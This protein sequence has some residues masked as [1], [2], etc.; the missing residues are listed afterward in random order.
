LFDRSHRVAL[1][2]AGA[3]FVERAEQLLAR[4][5]DAAAEARARATSENE[6]LRVGTFAQTAGELMR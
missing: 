5:A 6:V 2:P 1:T 3:A 4:L